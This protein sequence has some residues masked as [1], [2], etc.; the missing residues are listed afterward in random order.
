MDSKCPR[1]MPSRSISTIASKDTPP[2]TPLAP[3]RQ[4][5]EYLQT[6]IPAV[7]QLSIKPIEFIICFD[8]FNLKLVH[9]SGTI[10]PFHYEVQK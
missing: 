8:I 2:P 7:P 10:I 9:G 5:R 1:T 6:I 4:G 3:S